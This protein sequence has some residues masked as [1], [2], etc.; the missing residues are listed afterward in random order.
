SSNL[1]GVPTAVYIHGADTDNP[2]LRLTGSTN[3][4]SATQLTYLQDGLGSVVGMATP[5]GVLSASQRFDAWGNRTT[6]SGSV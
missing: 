4:P 2:I 3:T 6:G 1:T 5:A